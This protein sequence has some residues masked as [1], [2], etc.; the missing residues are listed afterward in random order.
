MGAGVAKQIAAAFPEAYEVDKKDSRYPH[1]KLGNYSH[2][3]Y[4]NGLRVVNLYTQYRYGRDRVHAEYAAIKSSL[5]EMIYEFDMRD[6]D[7]FYKVGLVK[8]GCGL[9]GLDWNIVED[10]INFCFLGVKSSVVIYT[11]EE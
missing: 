11:G 2:Y 4:E 5:M 8:L 9:G 3:T 7:V 6:R 10:I 1:V